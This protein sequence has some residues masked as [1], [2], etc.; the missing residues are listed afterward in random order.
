MLPGGVLSRPSILIISDDPEFARMVTASWQAGRSL[1]EI[2]VATADIWTPAALAGYSL[3]VVGP[4]SN[5][6]LRNM[7]SAFDSARAAAV[8]S[9]VDDEKNGAALE[10]AHPH[11][12]F[13][14]RQDGWTSTLMALSTEAMRRVEAVRRAQR[15][16]RI[17]HENQGY[18][19]L[20]RY[21]LE[22][23]SSVNDA[24]TSVLGNADLLLEPGEALRNWRD[25]LKTIHAMALRLNEIMQRFSS[26][27]SEIRFGETESHS[28]TE[29]AGERL[30]GSP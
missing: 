10:A 6:R 28:E 9:V 13:M 16:E 14:T 22:M 23:R 25:Q 3:V 27:A 11:V 18:A 29:P 30:V 17:A 1:P 19:S 2:T 26:L 21:M 12:I 8:I 15:A 24:L 4:V 5:G 20:G 7:L